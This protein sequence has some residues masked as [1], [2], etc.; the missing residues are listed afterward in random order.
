MTI[1]RIAV[2]PVV[3]CL[4][5]LSGMAAWAHWTAGSLPGGNGAAT[6]TTVGHGMTPSASAAGRTVTVTWPASTLAGGQAVDGYQVRRYDSVTLVAQTV[7]SAC[8]GTVTATSCVESNVPQGSWAYTVTPRFATNWV[9]AESAR[10]TAVVVAAAPTVT[11][12]QAAGQADPTG[13]SPINFTVVFSE[14]VT[15]F[16][17]ADVTLSGTAGGTRP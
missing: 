6:A 11:I 1:R 14:A 8:A 16:A 7:T 4:L 13:A 10:S 17:S 15:G 12:N 3:L 2:V 9:G 5:L